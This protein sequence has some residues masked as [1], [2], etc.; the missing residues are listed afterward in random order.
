MALALIF[1]TLLGFVPYLF[2]VWRAGEMRWA[3]VRATI[4]TF[5][6]LFRLILLA[7]PPILSNDSARYLWTG[8]LQLLGLNPYAHA[9]DAPAIA[10][11]RDEHWSRLEGRDAP[12][13]YAPLMLL[14][15]RLVASL[16]LHPWTFKLLF[17]TAD[18]LTLWF[19]VQLLRARNQNE[20]LALIWALNPLVILEFAGNGHG[21]S[22]AILFFVVGLWLHQHRLTPLAALG[23]AASTLTHPL[24]L[25][26]AVTMLAASR[27][28]ALRIW[29]WFGLPVAT[30]FALFADAGRSVWAGW[31]HL[32]GH[33][34]FN[35]SL[36]E[37]VSALLD[38][39]R[40]LTWA[41]IEIFHPGTKALFAAVLLGLWIELIR[42]RVPAVRATLTIAG[43]LLL[44]GAVVQ[45]WYVTWLVALVC[46]EF[47]L[48]WLMFS[49]TVLVSYVARVAQLQVGVGVDTA[50]TRWVQYVPLYL[51]LMSEA[52]R[53][54]FDSARL[55]R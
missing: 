6:V 26:L 46:L 9:P 7:M 44:L 23:Y 2:L 8:R 12:A 15:F 33:W 32:L 30:G 16:D 52:W 45:P 40:K 3:R 48:G 13:V 10:H 4:V 29:L 18:L 1:I 34:Q 51:L 19:L 21:M 37:I 31:L 20:S 38:G 39:D 53:N 50:F 54:R 22:L 25:P 47:R 24:A 14:L 5:A 43:A 17:M 36:Y 28:T 35:G 41:G 27:I 42:R 11:L 55:A 49:A